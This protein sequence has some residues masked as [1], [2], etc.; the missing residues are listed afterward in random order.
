V[1]GEVLFHAISGLATELEAA[2][3]SGAVVVPEKIALTLAPIEPTASAPFGALGD[4]PPEGWAATKTST[5]APPHGWKARAA[6]CRRLHLEQRQTLR[7]HRALGTYR[8][9]AELWACP[10]SV[11]L[12]IDDHVEL[13][14]KY[15]GTRSGLRYFLHKV[16]ESSWPGAED[17]LRGYLGVPPPERR[18]VFDLP[19]E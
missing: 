13:P 16:G 8:P 10:T 3:L 7:F 5:G 9:A 1:L 15:L 2:D 14:A 11:A 12:Q 4:L 6:A 18:Y 19:S 17:E